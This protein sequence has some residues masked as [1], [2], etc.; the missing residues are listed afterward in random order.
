[1][2]KEETIKKLA[3]MIKDKY[4]DSLEFQRDILE[5]HAV[6]L[7]MTIVA[8]GWCKMPEGPETYHFDCLESLDK[9]AIRR[10]EF[11]EEALAKT[12]FSLGNNG[13]WELYHEDEQNNYR[14]KAKAIIKAKTELL[15]TKG[16]E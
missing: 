11:N 8:D 6:D 14:E 9:W 2:T 10:V 5:L 13:T 3:A 12:L 16:G 1:M 7:A 15:K 4:W